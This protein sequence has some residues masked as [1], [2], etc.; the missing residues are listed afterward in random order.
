MCMHFDSRIPVLKFRFYIMKNTLQH[1]YMLYIITR[2]VCTQIDIS[3]TA[4]K[5][6][7]LIY[8]RVDALYITLHSTCCSQLGFTQIAGNWSFT[9]VQY[10][11]FL[12]V[13]AIEMLLREGVVEH[14]QRESKACLAKL[15]CPCSHS[16]V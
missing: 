4:V 13:I 8:P 2:L 9:N 14:W 5:S 16:W 7:W 6:T 12:F 11:L 10:H 1:L 3:Q 15:Y